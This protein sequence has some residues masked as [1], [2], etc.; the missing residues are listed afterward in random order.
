MSVEESSCAPGWPLPLLNP[1][2]CDQPVCDPADCL[3]RISASRQ[4]GGDDYVPMLVLAAGQL[5][6][7]LPLLGIAD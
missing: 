2:G 4:D 7:Q 6:F 5:L 1:L 3:S